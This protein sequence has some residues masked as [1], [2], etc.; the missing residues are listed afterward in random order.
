MEIA[1]VTMADFADLLT[2]L[3]L[4]DRTVYCL[5]SYSGS[6][7]TWWDPPLVPGTGAR[8]SGYRGSER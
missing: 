3:L 8:Q 2:Q 5:M 6:P 1:K 4:V 7:V